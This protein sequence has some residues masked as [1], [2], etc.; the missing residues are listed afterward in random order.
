MIEFSGCV[1]KAAVECAAKPSKDRPTFWCSRVRVGRWSAEQTVVEATNG[2]ML[3]RLTMD[4]AFDREVYLTRDVVSRIRPADRVQID[5]LMLKVD[6]ED[7][8]FGMHAL[9]LDKPEQTLEVEGRVLRA[10]PDFDGIIPRGKRYAASMIGLGAEIIGR[11]SKACRQ[12]S[13]PDHPLTLRMEAGGAKEPIKLVG[14]S[15]FG[16]VVFLVMPTDIAQ[17]GEEVA[18]ALTRAA[19]KSVEAMQDAV[20]DGVKLTVVHD[21][22]ESVVADKRSRRS[23]RKDEFGDGIEEPDRQ[24]A[25]AGNS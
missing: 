16:D 6:D 23:R 17:E 22:V 12:L 8:G 9:L 4:K 18:E 5:G 2:V 14:K 11:V 24:T 1:L 25:A 15:Y 19:Q 13:A 7:G 3:M 21:G 20:P 10:W